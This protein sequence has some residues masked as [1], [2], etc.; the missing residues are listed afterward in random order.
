MKKYNGTAWVDTTL[1]QYKAATDT[2]TTLPVDIYADGNT[3]TV[4]ISGNTVQNGTPTPDNPIMPQGTGERTENLFDISTVEKGRIDNGEVGYKSQTS[5]L[6]IEG[7]TIYFTTTLIYRGVCSGFFEIPEGTET[8]TFDFIRNKALE[9]K[10]IFYDGTKTWLDQDC[11]PTLSN[12]PPATAN[13]PIGA[14]YVR[15]SFTGQISGGDSYTMSNLI[16]NLG[17]TAL[18]YEPYGYKIPI[19]SANTTMPVYLGEVETTRKVKKLA[20]DGTENWFSN[21]L[22]EGLFNLNI[23]DYIKNVNETICLCTHYKAQQNITLWTRVQD[24]CVCFYRTENDLFYL[25][26]SD[27]ST[28][29]AFKQYLAAQYATGTPVTVW[30]VLATPETGIVNE[31]LMKIGDYADTVSGITIPVTA[32]G[33]TLS[34]DTTVQPSEVSLSYTGWHDASVKEWDGSQ[35]NE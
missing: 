17:S 32:G 27:F 30:Y 21:H 2:V 26:D 33:D 7:G 22:P 6:T 31:P 3:A 13:V 11:V 9:V 20:L 8:I 23:Y 24:K 4:G 15:L 19:S 28:V 18:P 29:E 14:K 16:L 12:I 5:S 10:F 1:R 35:W 34:V 25:R